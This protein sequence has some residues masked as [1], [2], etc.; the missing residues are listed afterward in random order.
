MPLLRFGPCTSWQWP[1]H[2]HMVLKMVWSIWLF[3]GAHRCACHSVTSKFEA[4][5]LKRPEIAIIS[6]NSTQREHSTWCHL[7]LQH[8]QAPQELP[9]LHRHLLQ[10]ET[11]E[12]CFIFK[13]FLHL[14]NIT[15]VKLF[16]LWAQDHITRGRRTSSINS[17][18]IIGKS[19]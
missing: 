15:N 6:N 19:V 1:P 3:S 9:P 11:N 14:E 12:L 13:L 2:L 4:T 8:H 18:T 17:L 5:S 10:P 7:T 16:L